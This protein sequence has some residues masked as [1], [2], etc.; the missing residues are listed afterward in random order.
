MALQTLMNFISNKS[1]PAR[2]NDQGCWV[3]VWQH[4]VGHRFPIISEILCNL[5]MFKEPQGAPGVFAAREVFIYISVKH[6]ELRTV[7]DG[8]L[9]F[10]GWILC[11][12]YCLIDPDEVMK[13]FATAVA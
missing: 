10:G 1:Q 11:L 12:M 6:H 3:V 13:W 7:T 8:M 5:L 2:T 9:H 4:Q